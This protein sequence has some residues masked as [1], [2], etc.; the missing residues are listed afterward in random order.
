MLEK[1]WQK[2]SESQERFYLSSRL[3]PT[4][5]AVLLAFPSKTLFYRCKERKIFL[6]LL[7]SYSKKINCKNDT[8]Y[9]IKCIPLCFKIGHIFNNREVIN[10]IL[11][12]IPETRNNEENLALAYIFIT[13]L[14][15]IYSEENDASIMS[16]LPYIV[17]YCDKEKLFNKSLLPLIE[18]NNIYVE[19]I[20]DDSIFLKF[21]FE[22]V[23]SDKEIC[24]SYEEKLKKIN[25]NYYV[26]YKAIIALIFHNDT[27]YKRNLTK[28]ELRVL[29]KYLDYCVYGER[30]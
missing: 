13:Y 30:K 4:L 25:Y 15:C 8:F 9:L 6:K 12:N 1:Q 17:E 7:S 23:S 27:Y 29:R 3:Y 10:L 2:D 19:N 28:I 22:K 26:I 24:I 11:D 16:T 14:Y 5:G 21:I 20:S 18:R